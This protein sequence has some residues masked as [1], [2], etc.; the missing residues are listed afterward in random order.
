MRPRDLSEVVGQAHVLGPG[1]A[2]HR[3][4]ER[5][6]P[7]SMIFWGPPGSGKTTL[8][9]LMAQQT[10]ALFVEYSAV[11]SGVKQIREVIERAKMVRAQSGRRTILFIDEIH[12]FNKAQQDAFLPHVENGQIVLIGATTEN[13]SFEVIPALISR[14]RTFVLRELTADDLR[15]LVE[16]ALVD[17][18]RGLGRDV[19]EMDPA[20]LDFLVN[21]SAGDARIALGTLE[22]AARLAREDGVPVR[23]ALAH[24]TEAIQA[25]PV[26]YDKSGEHHFNMI[27]AF[28]KSIRGSDPDAALY[29]MER[30]L[31][32]GEDPLY[33]AR[34]LVRIASEDV[35]LADPQALPVV[36]AARQAFAMLGSPEGEL[37]LAEAVIYLATAPKSNS[38]ET[39]MKRARGRA[40]ETGH[41][42]VPLHIRNAVSTIGR[43]EGYGCGYIYDH[44]VPGSYAG[45]EFL[46]EELAGETYYL[47]KQLGFEREIVRRMEWFRKRKR[48]QQSEVND[49][50]MEV[51]DWQK[52]V[53]HSDQ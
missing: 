45:Q 4:I 21:A 40:E 31:V 53:D 18:D 35:G 52:K 8:A 33:I 28:Q 5:G 17:E 50:R 16:R 7:V 41:L 22:L 27:S 26:A 43:Q 14:C 30:M 36:I 2:L 48:E 32:G 19:A 51:N 10:D 15:M 20:A 11:L 9:R 1:R 6:I 42:G 39:A 49:R 37:A 44:D 34:R 38:V 24:I 23:I 47:P 25:R 3:V 13:P 12:R 46:P 29:W